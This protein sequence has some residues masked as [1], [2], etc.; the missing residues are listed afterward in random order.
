[1]RLDYRILWIENDS[2][3][4][5]STEDMIKDSLSELGYIIKT[6]PYK[7][8][9]EF[10]ENTDVKNYKSYDLI[11]IDFK[12]DN[13]L[14]GD[15]FIQNVRDNNVYT[16]II[17][18]SQNSDE[19]QKRF[20]ELSLEGVYI[21]NREDFEDKFLQV[22]RK[23]IKK[24]EELNAV[25]GL[26]MAETSRLDNIIIDILL[27]H[28]EKEEELKKKAIKILEDS[29]KGLFIDKE[30]KVNERGNLKAKD[31]DNKKFIKRTLDASKRA[32]VLRKLIEIK[33][34]DSE[35]DYENYKTDVLDKR[36]ELAHAHSK[37][38]E[39]NGV[40]INEVLVVERG[41]DVVG[42]EYTSEKI[43]EIRKKILS[44]DEILEDLKRKL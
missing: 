10:I 15:T 14:T 39:N 2:D 6:T 28:F 37:I 42:D 41:E 34:I 24:L 7:D 21:S 27:E 35:F 13:D 12:L 8:Y 32:R 1:M 38:T 20:S 9:Q 30:K 11:L 25:R 5:E 23:T 19:L 18:Y 36:N 40:I 43:I 29:A 3:W 17:F 26:V 31:L 44:Y 22:F 4:Q 16:D 33:K